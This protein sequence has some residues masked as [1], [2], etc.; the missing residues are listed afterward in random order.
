MND[1]RRFLA[2][3]GASTLAM[4]LGAFAQQAT[5]VPRLGIL[6]FNSPQIDPIAPLLQGLQARGYVDGK[7]IAIEYRFAEGRAERLPDLAAELVRLG[8]DVIFAFGGDVAPHVKKATAS[9]PIAAM[10][11]NDPVQSGLVASLGR[12]GANV[13]GITLIYDELA[14]KLLE[15]LKQAVP[16]MSRI[17]VLWNP[18]HADP[19]FRETQR[20]AAAHAV[21]LQSLEVRQ[22]GDFAQA[23][24]AATAARAEGLIIVS[25]RLLLQQR[26]QI[27]EFGASNR[28]IMAGNWRDW[29]N[30]GLLLTFGPNPAVAMELIAGYVDKILKGVRPSDLPFERP[31]RFELVLNMKTAKALNIEIPPTLL[32]RADEVIE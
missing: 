30:D 17:A 10:V 14:G 12:P 23:F 22:P 29:A 26:R 19:E 1:R 5:P 28:I 32:A 21:Q 6:L 4:P 8:P 2:A 15:V 13:T 24:T 7:T 11:S 3:L 20:A 25:T 27:V 31:T 18:D 16:T 9:I